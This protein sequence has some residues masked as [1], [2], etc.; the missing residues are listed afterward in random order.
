M[1]KKIPVLVSKNEIFIQI[2]REK[3][4]YDFKKFWE[5]NSLF[6]KIYVNKQAIN[7][8]PEN[9]RENCLNLDSRSRLDVWDW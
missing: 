9:S 7:V 3:K 1:L 4:T 6:L 5:N 8:I 2:S